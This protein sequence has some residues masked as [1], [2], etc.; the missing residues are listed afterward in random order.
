M[1]A[2]SAATLYHLAPLGEYEQA[3]H[4]GTFTPRTYEQVGS[5]AP[6][7]SG[8]CSLTPLA[9]FPQDGFTHL[10]ADAESL[11]DIGNHFYRDTAGEFVVLSLDASKL[12]GEVK[13][14]PA[15]GVGETPPHV[16]GGVAL[17]PHLV[18]V[19]RVVRRGSTHV[20]ISFSATAVRAHQSGCSDRSHIC[21]PHAQREDAWLVVGHRG[22]P[23]KSG[24]A[25]ARSLVRCPAH[26]FECG[27]IAVT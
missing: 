13:W 3:A 26:G 15:A 14:E 11:V 23:H 1:S 22:R 10:T 24:L 18:R 25:Q 12:K 8:H 19:E 20:V 6:T 9:P 27:G 16:T 7:W 17:F 21:R 4:T 5:R 2:P